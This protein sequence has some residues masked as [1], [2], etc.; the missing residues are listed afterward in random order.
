MTSS[1]NKQR[2][3]APALLFSVENTELSFRAKLLED[4]NPQL[5]SLVMASLPIK[6]FAGH[7][8]VAGETL[9]M[10]TQIVSLTHDNMV[11]REPGQVYFYGAG[12][13]FNI[14]YGEVTEKNPVNHFAQIY[15][16][17]MEKLRS[18]GKLACEETF[19]KG[20]PK[21]LRI[22]VTLIN[23]PVAQKAVFKLPGGSL[24]NDLGALWDIV[25]NTIDRA[26]DRNWYDEPDEVRKVRL[27]LIDSGSGT[28]KQAFSILVH[29]KAY[30][31]AYGGDMLYRILKTVHREE[32]TLPALKTTTKALMVDSFDH[33]EFAGHDL[34]MTTLGDLGA[35]YIAAL[36]TVTT[37]DQYIQL[38]GSML[39]FINLFHRWIHNVFPWHYGSEHPHRTQEEIAGEPKLVTYKRP[40]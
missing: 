30:L 32:M 37:K 8:V 6:T 20:V 34:G 13:Q 23:A 1:Q 26:T 15:E 22:T 5:V 17:D 35:Q 33:F 16:E 10:P 11:K 24:S 19:T 38:T 4:K 21:V 9:W 40:D 7:V 29:L 3:E 25:K 27:G 31:M 12:T 36:D 28:R 2:D 14:C 18:V 39:I